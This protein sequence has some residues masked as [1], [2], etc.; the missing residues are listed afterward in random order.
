MSAVTTSPFAYASR[1]FSDKE[2]NTPIP[3]TTVDADISFY[4]PR[5]DRVFLHQTGE[6]EV[7]NGYP[8]ITPQ[9]PQPVDNAIEM[10]ELFEFFFG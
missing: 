1:V 2:F 9:K 8:D 4:V 10:F 6:F 3:G 5:I 7:V